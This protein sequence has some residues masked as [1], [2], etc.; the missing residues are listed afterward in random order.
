MMMNSGSA[1]SSCVVR[2]FQAY[3]GSSRSIGT[4][5]KRASSVTPVRPRVRPIQSPPASR[6]NSRANIVTTTT[7]MTASE[8]EPPSVRGG[9][10]G[11]RKDGLLR[12]RR[13]A[14]RGILELEPPDRLDQAGEELRRQQQEA[15]GDQ[16][17]GYP[18]RQ[19][20]GDR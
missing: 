12:Y 18:E 19:V 6:P 11:S 14:H 7:S 20:T 5:R 13:H 15:E 2:M 4:S 16:A 17:L 10:Q 3:C 1:R 9:G 8:V